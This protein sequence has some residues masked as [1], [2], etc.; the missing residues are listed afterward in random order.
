MVPRWALLRQAAFALGFGEVIRMESATD[1][2]A[3]SR[4]SRLFAFPP[5]ARSR[6]PQSGETWSATERRGGP[7]RAKGPWSPAKADGK[8]P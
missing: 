3:T 2:S 7:P 8:R 4:R 5:L 1:N 6:P